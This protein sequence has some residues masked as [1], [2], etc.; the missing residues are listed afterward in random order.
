MDNLAKMYLL[1]Y[2]LNNQHWHIELNVWL[3]MVSI[4]PSA[5]QRYK[6]IVK[7]R[8]KTGAW[9]ALTFSSKFDYFI[10]KH[11]ASK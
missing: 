6:G 5:L 11:M 8:S 10:L 9:G 4:K 7:D 3:N 2:K 1:T